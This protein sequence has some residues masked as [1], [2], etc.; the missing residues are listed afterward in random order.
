MYNA[1]LEPLITE[2]QKAIEMAETGDIEAARL[3]LD[4]IRYLRSVMSRSKQRGQDIQSELIA[5]GADNEELLGAYAQLA[6][7]A[8]R[9][10]E[11]LRE[12]I[13][14]SRRAFT[15]DELRASQQGMQL[16][17]DDAL[18]GIWDFTQDVV[19]LTQRDGE[20]LRDVLRN[21]GQRRFVWIGERG[22]YITEST[23]APYSKDEDTVYVDPSQNPSV[24][25]MKQLVGEGVVPRVAL[26][27]HQ[28]SEW[29]EEKFAA[30][31][32]AIASSIVR[33][34]TTQ[35]LAKRNPEQYLGNIAK[36]TECRSIMSLQSMFAG[37]DVLVLSPGP[38]LRKDFA[39]LKKCASRFITIAPVKALEALFDEG[40]KP[41]FSIWQDPQD[42][43]YAIPDRDEIKDVPLIL[44]ECCHAA[45]F[46]APFKEH[47]IYPD[48]QLAFTKISSILHGE[49]RPILAGTCVST[50]ATLLATSMGAA[51][52]TLLGQDLS[53]GGGQ[54]VSAG[55]VSAEEPVSNPHNE[56]LMCQ[57][58]GGGELPT[59]PNYFDFIGEFKLIG[60]ALNK[61]HRLINCTSSG[62]YLGG[63]DHMPLAD[64][65]KLKIDAEPVVAYEDFLAE[66]NPALRIELN[67]AL[68]DVERDLQEARL[69]SRELVG[70]CLQVVHDQSND[71]TEIEVREQKLRA[72]L[73]SSHILKN[74]ISPQSMAMQA[75]AESA[76]SLE[77]NLRLSADYYESIFQSATR[78]EMLC[79]EARQSL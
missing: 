32:H 1:T 50:L 45:F 11:I 5:V 21:R 70:L 47:L 51:S 73:E 74:Y 67:Q 38:S 65:P 18:P 3:R 35:W 42:H 49:P 68:Q 9:L 44:G 56:S 64:H 28:C 15:M 46:G 75:A 71:V 78:L 8:N 25:A 33:A 22:D 29:E 41:D 24:D 26:V 59:Q 4:R 12:W 66:I 61:N 58:I 55:A 79:G 57:A 39:L 52:V 76:L 69:C 7:H 6:A 63:W 31:N 62:A 37:A 10:L 2:C 13:Q 48:P 17:I 36:F 27:A 40:I 54:Y 72:L 14:G 19:V 34:A 43:S 23:M 16:F 30:V 77:D 60:E 20:T 53:I